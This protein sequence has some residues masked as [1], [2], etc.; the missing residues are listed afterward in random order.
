MALPDKSAGPFHNFLA[1]F[2]QHGATYLLALLIVPYLLHLF[3]PARYGVLVMAQT[4][5]GLFVTLAD[6]GLSF[7]ATQAMV[8]C[9]E[10]P[11]RS[12][13][14]LV[15]VLTL[16]FW[17]AAAG[18]LV[19]G[20][21]VWRLR[22]SAPIYLTSYAAVLGSVLFPNWA[23]QGLERMAIVARIQIAAQLSSVSLLL[24]LVHD[25]Q[26]LLRVAAIQ[27]L[28][29]VL[30]GILG[31]VLLFRIHPLVVTR[32]RPPALMALLRNGFPVV[33]GSLS[34]FVFS[35]GN[36]F[37]AGLAGGPVVAGL[38]GAAWKFLSPVIGLIGHAQTAS[39]PRLSRLRAAGDPAAVRGFIRK[40][41]IWTV[42]GAS[43]A[44]L[45]LA[46]LAPLLVPWVAGASYLATIPA[47]QVLGMALP[48]IALNYVLTG[49]VLLNRGARWAFGSVLLGTAVIDL[50][51]IPLVTREWGAVGTAAGYVGVETFEWLLI[52][53]VRIPGFDLMTVLFRSRRQPG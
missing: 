1:L 33:T 51:L 49:A 28:T 7:T 20:L 42:G 31:L 2:T 34:A 11:E 48:V 19:Y 10:D 41:A 21:L 18:F 13:A 39:Y 22:L 9:R 5:C 36:L 4:L 27:A 38:Y 53:A 24:A 15:S 30:A 43:L 17:L 23:F 25:D 26:E 3:G 50:A 8:E 45:A 16:K 46:G 47:L 12:G 40:Y 37:L 29:P 35:T 32:P 6:Y 52:W 14:L 44:S